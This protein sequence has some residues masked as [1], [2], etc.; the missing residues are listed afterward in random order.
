MNKRQRK[1]K[2]RVYYWNYKYDCTTNSLYG[3]T[4]ITVCFQPARERVE[5]FVNEFQRI[6]K[7]NFTYSDTDAIYLKGE[8]EQ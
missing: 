6:I 2:G 7:R 4:P 1:K 8:D 5:R 3:I